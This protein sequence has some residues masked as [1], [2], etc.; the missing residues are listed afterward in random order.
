MRIMTEYRQKLSTA[1]NAVSVVKSGDW[2]DYGAFLTAPETLD[3]A[4]AMR[5][6]ELSFAVD[7]F[8]RPMAV[9]KMFWTHGCKKQIR[10]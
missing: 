5:I 3:A 7:G 6:R 4:L 10:P 1:S 8:T 9:L 2:V